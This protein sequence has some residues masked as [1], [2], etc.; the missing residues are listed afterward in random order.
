M[1][2]CKQIRT[3]TTN[4]TSSFS[5]EPRDEFSLEVEGQPCSGVGVLGRQKGVVADG[6]DVEWTDVTKS[7][8]LVKSLGN[9]RLS[10]QPNT[11]TEMKKV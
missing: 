3:I 4:V 9:L 2:L 10:Y 1:Q 6:T 11:E 5:H 7:S 8:L